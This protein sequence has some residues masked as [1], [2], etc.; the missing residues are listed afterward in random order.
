MKGRG[1]DGGYAFHGDPRNVFAQFFG[2]DSPFG[3][4]FGSAS[5]ATPSGFT[6]MQPGGSPG[7]AGFSQFQGFPGMFPEG[8]PEQMDFTPSGGFGAGHGFGPGAHKKQKSQDPPVE[9]PL[10]LSLEDLFHGCTKKMKI[11][12][13]ILSPDG[14]SSVQDKLLTIDVKPGWKAGTKITFP[15]EGDHHMGK[16][17][18]DIIF[19]VEEKPH[20][21]FTREGHD[22]V[23]RAKISLR[24]ALCG[25]PDSV[26][27]PTIEGKHIS[28]HLKDIVRPDTVRTFPGQGMPISK[29]PGQRGDLIV[30]FDIEFP[31]QLPPKSKKVISDVLP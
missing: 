12:R 15:K 21:C 2:G 14:T 6:F 8:G 29:H 26:I 16:V 19:V 30:K 17:P 9:S 3:N 10:R 1:G 27:I 18:A 4:F 31:T 25:T 5:G 23:H 7:A 13:K 20:S 24:D 11:S 22:L 28:I